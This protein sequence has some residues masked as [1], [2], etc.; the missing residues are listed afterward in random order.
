MI[1]SIAESTCIRSNGHA[2]CTA[3]SDACIGNTVERT[4]CSGC[5]HSVIGPSHAPMYQRLYNDLKEL[6]NYPDIGDGGRNRVE[7]DLCRSREVLSQ[8]GIDPEV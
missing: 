3:D 1:K 8:L 5:D 7:R 4:R 6:R 2:W